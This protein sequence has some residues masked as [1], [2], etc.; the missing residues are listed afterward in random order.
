MDLDF[1]TPEGRKRCY[2]STNTTTTTRFGVCSFLM[3]MLFY[4]GM[5]LNW[6]GLS[7][8]FSLA[9]WSLK[10]VT[11]GQAQ[12]WAMDR[13][14]YQAWAMGMFILICLR[15]QI[16]WRYF[17]QFKTILFSV[18]VTFCKQHKIMSFCSMVKITSFCSKFIKLGSHGPGLVFIV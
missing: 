13:W 4:L 3:N 15:M 18:N 2:T 9:C 16:K 1:T 12:A 14:C 11:M 10:Q 5:D 6:V 8:I 17:G 7:S